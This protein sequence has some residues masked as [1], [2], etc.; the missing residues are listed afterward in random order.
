MTSGEIKLEVR[1]N[2]RLRDHKDELASYISDKKIVFISSSSWEERSLGAARLILPEIEPDI[3]IVIEYN[4]DKVEGV[5]QLDTFLKELPANLNIKELKISN[6]RILPAIME[7]SS[8]LT[9]ELRGRKETALIFDVT[10]IPKGHLLLLL[11]ALELLNLRN[12]VICLYTQPEEYPKH[13]ALPQSNGLSEMVNVPTFYGNYDFA[14]ES[15]LAIVLGYEGDR[16]MA[17]YESIDPSQCV[18]FIPDPPYRK[19][20]IGRTEYFN[21]SLINLVGKNHVKKIDSMNPL[22]VSLQLKNDLS[23]L[24]LANKNIVIAPLGTKPQTV[25][26]YLYLTH[27]PSKRLISYAIPDIKN[28]L[29]NS[30]GIGDSWIL[31]TEAS[32]F[33]ENPTS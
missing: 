17:L 28:E 27:H 18:L 11:R 4:Q 8:I 2:L 21:K 7:M 15:V 19:E 31:R 10:T 12:Q 23:A 14:Q 16:S 6:E 25:G 32:F 24:D 20:W 29:E 26:L 3:C 9:N 30:T 22:K 5:S 33:R 13:L 1:P